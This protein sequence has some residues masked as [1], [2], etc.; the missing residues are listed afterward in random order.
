M[1]PILGLLILA[2]LLSTTAVRA[3]MP[4]TTY[5][6]DYWGSS[7]YQSQA[8]LYRDSITAQNMGTALSYPEDMFIK[9]GTIYVSDTGNGRILLLDLEGNIKAEVK[10]ANGEED[11]LKSPKGIFVSREDHLYVADSGNGRIVEYDEN[12]NYLRSIGRPESDLIDAN[13]AYTPTGIV[14]DKAGRMYVIAYGINMGLLEFDKNGQFQGF[15]GAT[16][17]SVSMFQYVKKNYFSTEEQKKRMQTIVPT[18]YSNIFIDDKNFIYAT[19]SNLT[20]EDHEQGA[21]MIRRLNPTGTDVLRRLGNVPVTGDLFAASEDAKWSI[22]SDV[23]AS[24]FGCYFVLDSASAKI[25]AY[26][27]DGN[28]M[29]VFGNTGAREGTGKKVKAIGLTDDLS[30]VFVLDTMLGCIMRYEIT[31]YGTHFI[32]ALEKNNRGDAKGAFEE[33]Q[34]VLELNSNCELAYIGIGKTFL[35][36]GEYKEAM[37]YFELGNSRKYYSTAFNYYRRDLMQE[38][39]PKAMLIVGIILLGL[40]GF[41]GVRKFR[42]WVDKVEHE[43][44][45]HK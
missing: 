16:E 15:M 13:Q 34:R 14:V 39:F 38:Y 9:D 44:Y 4:Y 23:W 41:F 10:T 12:L 40:L 25:F 30:E 45:G 3:D 22:F 42:R 37:K 27:Y 29:F 8:Y 21:D 1:K 32:A 7:V 2:V 43:V 35:K 20:E 18:E 5:S 6:Y 17:V 19:I 28:S 33:W 36:R 26:D 24:D 11:L 31:E